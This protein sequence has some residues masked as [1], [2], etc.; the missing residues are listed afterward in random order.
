[1]KEKNLQIGLYI[2]SAM[3][4]LTGFVTLPSGG[5]VAVVSGIGDIVLTV[6]LSK[7]TKN[8]TKLLMTKTMKSSV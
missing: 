8:L 4:I 7:R 3:S 1:M 2:V 6:L 5:I